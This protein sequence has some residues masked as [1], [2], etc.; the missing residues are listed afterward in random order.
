MEK[1]WYSC[2]CRYVKLND[3]G[4]EQK[5]TEEFLL[6]AYNYTEAEARMTRLI[7]DMGLGLFE[8]KQVVKRNYAEVI[9]TGEGDQW[10]KIKIA[11]ISFDENSGKEKQANQY[12]LIEAHNV[13]DA[14]ERVCKFME[15]TISN[16]VIPQITHTKIL[17]VFPMADESEERNQILDQGYVDMGVKSY[18]DT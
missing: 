15:G 8:V 18:Q 11:F 13:K 3:E 4:R 16:F 10:Y 12:F 2:K 9:R 6:D 5:V 1:I 17:D 7:S 14:Y